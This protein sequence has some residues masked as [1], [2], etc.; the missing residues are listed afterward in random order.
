VR[1]P[2]TLSE[3]DR[4]TVAAWAADCAER[5]LPIFE[6]AAPRDGRPR[7]LI[8]R[9]RAFARGELDVAEGIRPPLRRWRPGGR[10]TRSCSRGG[11]SSG[12]TS[13][14]HPSYGRPCP[15]RSRLRREGAGLAAPDR[16]DAVSE[17]IRWQL[18]HMSTAVRA[19]LR[20]L[21]PVGENAAGP[22]WRGLLASGSL[23]AII[24]DLQ[25]SLAD[26]MAS[27]QR[28]CTTCRSS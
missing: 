27:A 22:L 13:R 17:E 7:D 5:V 15:R 8:A 3:G 19:A 16:A 25:A 10:Y 20:L 1:S 2:Q 23:A 26:S 21:P 28:G 11:R 4:R 9:T 12:R 6:A 14:S 24:G 18:D